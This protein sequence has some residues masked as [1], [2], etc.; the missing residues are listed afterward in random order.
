MIVS[1]FYEMINDY[2]LS[3]RYRRRE[4]TKSILEFIYGGFELFL[5]G[6]WDFLVFSASE[7][8]MIK[9]M[10]NYKRG[11]FIEGIFGQVIVEY[12]KLEEVLK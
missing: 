11:R 6:V 10:S 4:E 9:L 2:K 12:Q 8:I 5:Y 7:E 1:I 3:I